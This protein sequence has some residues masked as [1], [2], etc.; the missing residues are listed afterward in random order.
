MSIMPEAPDTIADTASCDLE[1][2]HLV[3][4]CQVDA[5]PRLAL[6][7]ADCTDGRQQTA[8]DGPDGFCVV[9]WSLRHVASVYGCEFCRSEEW[10][11]WIAST[12]W[13]SL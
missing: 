1:P 7:L 2:T 4:P 9:C 11:E 5:V 6:C 10:A 3:C 8:P 13:A 12:D